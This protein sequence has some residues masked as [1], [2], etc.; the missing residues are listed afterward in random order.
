M[1]PAKNFKRRKIVKLSRHGLLE[2]SKLQAPLARKT[3]K[4]PFEKLFNS[5]AKGFEYKIN[6]SN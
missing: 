6:V 2:M 1:R 3:P 5:T 4:A